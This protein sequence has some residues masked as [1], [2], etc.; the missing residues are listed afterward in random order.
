MDNLPGSEVNSTDPLITGIDASS[1]W[2]FSVYFQGYQDTDASN[3]GL[4]MTA[5]TSS[6]NL[7][8]GFPV[9]GGAAFT[10]RGTVSSVPLGSITDENYN[11]WTRVSHTARFPEGTS[12]INCHVVLS[13]IGWDSSGTFYDTGKY[14]ALSHAKLEQG[15]VAT[16]FVAG[17][18]E[19]PPFRFKA[20]NNPL[21]YKLFAKRTL[22]DNLAK[23]S[24]KSITEPGAIGYKDLTLVWRIKFA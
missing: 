17:R 23:I 9:S 4:H 20:E 22:T 8:Y 15:T 16:D 19:Y 7:H 11:N 14:V 3:V 10:Q 12:A 18:N 24:D 1:D 5:M 6:T 13:S 21:R 2:T